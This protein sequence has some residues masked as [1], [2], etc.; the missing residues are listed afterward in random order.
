MI[1]RITRA[2][3]QRIEPYKVVNVPEARRC[4][5][6]RGGCLQRGSSVLSDLVRRRRC[7]SGR[8]AGVEA[9]IVCRWMLSKA[10]IGA[11]SPAGSDG[12]KKHCGRSPFR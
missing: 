4:G 9:A 5:R 3:G 12:S 7:A 11:E 10:S 1:G 6:W 2:S 8:V